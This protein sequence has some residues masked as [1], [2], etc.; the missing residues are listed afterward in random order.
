MF[1]AQNDTTELAS[2]GTIL[3]E[4]RGVTFYP[5]GTKKE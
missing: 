3:K 2:G 5:S 1:E 4:Y